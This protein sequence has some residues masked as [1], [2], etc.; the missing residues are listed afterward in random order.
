MVVRY[1]PL[2]YQ[3]MDHL[4]C[5]MMNAIQWCWRSRVS[6]RDVLEQYLEETLKL[7]REE[8]FAAPLL[9]GLIEK[10]GQLRWKSGLSQPLQGSFQRSLTINRTALPTK[11]ECVV[12]FFVARKDQMSFE[13]NSSKFDVKRPTVILL[14]ALMSASR[15]GYRRV[16]ERINRLG[17]NVLFPH[18]PFHYD[19]SGVPF[20]KGAETITPDLV[21]TAE[22]V[23]QAVRE[24]RQLIRY[25]RMQGD[26]PIYLVGTS[27]GGWIASLLLSLELVEGASLL[28]PMVDL[29]EATFFGPLSLVLGPLLLRAGVEVEQ[30]ER[31]A[32][33]TSPLGGKPFPQTGPITIIGGA[34]DR[35]SPREKLLLCAQR[36]PNTTYHEV[37]QGH[38]GYRAMG[39][40]L[41]LLLPQLRSLME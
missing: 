41:E 19:R 3:G 10:G 12:D 8:F 24:M 27:Y 14:H 18:L 21:H 15:F 39:R 6:S 38:F 40:A 28:Q 16:A 29:A 33:L 22:T 25:L 30:V 23:R 4:M 31:H 36:W 1:S 13:R 32:V 35:L 17:W 26:F 34:Y 37:L 20:L 9:S 5:G 11:E 2:L 7:S